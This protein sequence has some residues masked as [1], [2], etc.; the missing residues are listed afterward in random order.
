MGTHMIALACSFIF[1]GVLICLFAA[2]SWSAGFTENPLTNMI[3]SVFM[4]CCCPTYFGEGVDINIWR[5]KHPR[6]FIL[7]LS[8]EFLIGSAFIFSG[9]YL[10][11]M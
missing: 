5:S 7:W 3:L 8:F 11:I 10:L 1:F 4:W 9:I 2:L 6:F